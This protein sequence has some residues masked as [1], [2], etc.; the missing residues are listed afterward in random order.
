MMNGWMD[1]DQESL[2]ST[3]KE[4]GPLLKYIFQ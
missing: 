2:L 4:I 3:A 1:I